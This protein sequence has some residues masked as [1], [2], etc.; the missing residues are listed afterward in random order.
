MYKLLLVTDQ[1]N[2]RELFE[3]QLDWA[4]L[5][6]R[7]PQMIA[8]AEEAIELL[9]TAAVDAVGYYLNKQAAVPLIRY[10]RYGRPSLPIFEVCDQPEKQQAILKETRM[11]LDRLHADFS[12]EYYDEDAML[13]ILRD[14]LAHQ[15]LAGEIREW[16]ALERSLQLIRARVD[17]KGV[18]VAY[19][20]DMPQGE[21][22]LSEHQH[23]QERLE[24]A[25]RNNFFGRYVDGIFYAVAVLTPR[26][27][28]LVCMPMQADEPE[29]PAAF[30]ARADEHIQDSIQ[31][32]KEYLDLDM[33]V[34]R[35]AWLHKG[36]RELIEND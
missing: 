17:P 29:A 26:H 16:P 20:I 31:Q 25:L 33:T 12:D 7:K 5:G 8:T 15:L 32:I 22:Y 36:L 35:S 23:A 30:A 1:E 18:C 11:L 14:E 3:N 19:E 10:L 13:T 6:C 27:I 34:V 2:I 21:V 24:S 28:R 4:A 9:N